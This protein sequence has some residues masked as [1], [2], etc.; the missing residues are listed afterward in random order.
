MY[1]RASRPYVWGGSRGKCLIVKKAN[2]NLGYSP[3]FLKK[4]SRNNEEGLCQKTKAMVG[5]FL[6]MAKLYPLNLQ[7]LFNPF[8][9]NLLLDSSV[10]KIV[11][12]S[13]L[14]EPLKSHAC[15]S[16]QCTHRCNN[17]MGSLPGA[18]HKPLRTFQ[19][20][21]LHTW[22]NTWKRHGISFPWLW[23]FPGPAPL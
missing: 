16:D 21:P 7:A 13:L 15:F 6:A 19:F 17:K 22:W 20:A 14:L 8:S 23:F 18:I 9:N 11:N 5:F 2:E 12:N 1:F 10:T 4:F 3:C